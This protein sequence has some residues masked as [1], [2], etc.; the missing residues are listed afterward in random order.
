MGLKNQLEDFDDP[1]KF[2][3]EALKSESSRT[4]VVART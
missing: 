1:V 3:N 2:R 4:P